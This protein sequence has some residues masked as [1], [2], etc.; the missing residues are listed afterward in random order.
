MSKC[1]RFPCFVKTHESEKLE[2]N[3][4]K[5]SSNPSSSSNSKSF[6]KLGKKKRNADTT[7]DRTDSQNVEATCKDASSG[8][9][10]AM[11]VATAHLSHDDGSACGSS[12]GDGGG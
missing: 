6:K 11:I 2:E 10:A 5:H 4:L 8:S 3:D 12:H 9:A 1:F 7:G